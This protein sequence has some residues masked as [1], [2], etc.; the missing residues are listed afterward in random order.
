MESAH[1][2]AA[3]DTE[4]N[5]AKHFTVER[6]A[7][8]TC[9]RRVTI[10]FAGIC[11]GKLKIVTCFA[12]QKKFYSL[13][14]WRTKHVTISS[15]PLQMP[16]KSIVTRLKHVTNARRAT[17]K[18]ARF[19]YHTSLELW[20]QYDFPLRPGWATALRVLAHTLEYARVRSSTLEYARVRSSTH[21]Y[22]R[23]RSSTH[24]YARVRSSTLEYARVRSSTLEYARVRSST[25]EYARVRS[26]TLEYARV[27]T[28]TLE[29]ARVRSSTLEY[30]RV[31]SSTHE[32][33][34][35]RSSTLEYA[36][37]RSSALECSRVRSS[38]LE[39]ARVRSSTLEYAHWAAQTHCE[40]TLDRRRRIAKTHW[41]GED[42]LG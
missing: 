31:R 20:K 40:D 17:R 1:C 11:K 8:V 37:V 15:F 27:R 30:A 18:N 13:F 2:A 35:V 14:L 3:G 24:E 10:V 5:G 19:R 16:A 34:R 6:R 23:V 41:V 22:A 29:Y 28:I 32:Y 26:S 33:A 7:I 36:R 9:F 4:Q 39:Y 25:L 21:E 42:A 12:R 38:A